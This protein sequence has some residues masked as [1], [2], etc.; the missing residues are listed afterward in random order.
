MSRYFINNAK[1]S[2]LQMY[3]FDENGK[4]NFLSGL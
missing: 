4:E 2:L 1:F 3:I